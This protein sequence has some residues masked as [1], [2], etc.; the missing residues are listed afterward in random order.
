M[1]ERVLA[2]RLGQ[3]YIQELRRG[4]MNAVL[5]KR[6][7]P[8]VGITIARITNDLSTVRNWVSMSVPPLA[9]AMALPLCI[10][11][12]ALA[13]FTRPAFDKARTLRRKRGRLAAQVSDTVAATVPVRAAGGE[14]REVQ[15]IQRLG[16]E[17][18]AA[19]IDRARVGGYIRAP[20]GVSG[21]VTVAIVAA[22]KASADL[23]VRISGLHLS[24]NRP[25]P[26]LVAYPGD[27]VLLK[28]LDP[29]EA[30]EL[31]EALLALRED[32][33]LDTWVGD[34]DLRSVSGAERRGVAGYGAKGAFTERGTISRTVRY[35]RP[36]LPPGETAGALA[37]IGLTEKVARLPKG[38]HTMLQRGGEPLSGSDRA[39]LQI[40][41]ATL[42][43]PPLLLLNHVDFDLGPE[44]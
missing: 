28:T 37:R 18:A 12:V 21:A 35:R 33:P 43:N 9:V 30:T 23:I 17:V 11:S 8:S 16:G 5:A 2:E 27:R 44:G 36:D 13:L 10:L 14:R 19:A 40:A 29:G 3:S 34:R 1:A 6:D 38:E 20:A 7:G 42:G 24:G 15:Q 25:V 4:L 39:R 26:D 32:P 31:F 41:R 22:T